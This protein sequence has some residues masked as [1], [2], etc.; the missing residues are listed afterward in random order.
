MKDL[1][2]SEALISPAYRNL[3][4]PSYS[5]YGKWASSDLH[6]TESYQ[7]KSFYKPIILNR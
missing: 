1:K 4:E 2:I 6:Q 7:L 3:Q 5:A